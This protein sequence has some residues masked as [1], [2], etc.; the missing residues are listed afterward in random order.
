M[1]LIVKKSEDLEIPNVGNEFEICALPDLLTNEQKDLSVYSAIVILGGDG[2][3]L[4]TI[5]RQ[6]NVPMIYAF[7]YGTLGYLTTYQRKDFINLQEILKRDKNFVNR[8][9][10][11][12]SNG[13][14]FLN[15]VVFTSRSHR[16]NTF[17]LTINDFELVLKGDSLLIS[18]STGSTG[19]NHS[20][21]GPV[22][23]N[24]SIVINLVAPNKCNFRPLVLD[25]SSN[26]K[27]K[28]L[29]YDAIIIADGIEY[30]LNDSSV[31]YDGNDVKFACPDGHN[32]NFFITKFYKGE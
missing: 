28:N 31:S 19:Y 24:D 15:E 2:T 11:L 18:T 21:G 22:V 23:L 8:R 3:I 12:L 29:A 16:L 17:Y 6:K 7:N 13:I 1:I 25:L 5:S 32:P 30:C 26:I 20:A 9:R 14:Y 10:L 27:V 4:R